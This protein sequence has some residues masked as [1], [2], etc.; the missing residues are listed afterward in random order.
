MAN[1]GERICEYTVDTSYMTLIRPLLVEV[2]QEILTFCRERAA[3]MRENAGPV[4][5]AAGIIAILVG[6]VICFHNDQ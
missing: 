5:V 3:N 1:L 4:I 6:G 2:L